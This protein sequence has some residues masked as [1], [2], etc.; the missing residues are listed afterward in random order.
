MFFSSFFFYFIFGFR[1]DRCWNCL[2]YRYEIYHT[3]KG[4]SQKIE[5][6]QREK[7][8]K[9]IKWILSCYFYEMNV[10]QNCYWM[11]IESTLYWM[12]VISSLHF[13]IHLFMIFPHI[14]LHLLTFFL[15]SSPPT[16]VKFNGKEIIVG[17]SKIRFFLCIFISIERHEYKKFN[18]MRKWIQFMWNLIRSICLIH[19][20]HHI[21]IRSVGTW[22]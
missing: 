16:T 10:N 19:F 14:S 5:S 15:P 4:E 8:E 13:H 17:S 18:E 3:K 6:T 21:E 1:Y 9:G 22:A 20:L 12:F 2:I 11:K 7:S